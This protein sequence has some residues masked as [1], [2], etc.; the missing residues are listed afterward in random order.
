MFFATQQWDLA[1]FTFFNSVLR[2]D[3]LDP[4][5]RLF[6]MSA[7]LWL[8]GA[9]L[10]VGAARYVGVTRALGTA[11]FL[12]LALGATDQTVYRLKQETMRVRPLNVLAGT[13]YYED[14]AWRQ[15]P[16]SFQQEK[17][18]GNSYP[19][20]HAANSMAAALALGL[21]LPRVRP[22]IFLVPLFA[23]WS[24]LY[25][26]KHYPS[27]VLAGWMTG[28][29]VSG[30]LYGWAYA[31]LPVRWRIWEKDAGGQYRERK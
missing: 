3:W 31:F 16:A 30:L 22:W 4:V 29:V 24:R 23:G 25:L 17:K 15:R 14:G 9:L 18:T 13:H 21:C 20:G 7:M 8:I 12:L 28:M 6:S 5:M 1:V 26:G 11:L 10:L 19:S 2:A 27:D